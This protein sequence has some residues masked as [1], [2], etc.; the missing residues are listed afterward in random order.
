MLFSAIK[1]AVLADGEISAKEAAWLKQ[2]LYADGKIDEEEKKFLRDLKASARATSP[3]FEA[4]F[5][6]A[7]A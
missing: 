1:A 5:A 4:L 3:E 6:Q 2:F 7:T